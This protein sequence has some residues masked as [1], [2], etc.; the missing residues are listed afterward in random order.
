MVDIL[1][2]CHMYLF[3]VVSTYF[4]LYLCPR[5]S[6]HFNLGLDRVSNTNSWIIYHTRD[7]KSVPSTNRAQI[8]SIIFSKAR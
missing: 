2:N 3:V 5:V 8:S 6:T 1:V 7:L 4:Y